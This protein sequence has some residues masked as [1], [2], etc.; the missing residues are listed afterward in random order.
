M[1]T[2]MGKIAEMIQTGED[3]TTPLQKRLD[4]LGKGLATAALGICAVIL[5]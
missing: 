1:N 2:E 3:M 4:V 5:L